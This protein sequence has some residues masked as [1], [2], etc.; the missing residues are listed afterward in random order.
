MGKSALQVA[1]DHSDQWDAPGSAV[2]LKT[3][4]DLTNFA[5]RVA[6]TQMV[7]ASFQGKP[8]EIVACVMRGMELQIPPFLAMSNIAVINGRPTMWGDLMLGLV[9]RSGALED[10]QEFFVKGENGDLTAI[11]QVKRRGKSV[12][13]RKFSRKD[14]DRARLTTKKGPHQDYPK[15]MLQL[16]ARGFA[17]RD[18]FPD[19]LT[20]LHVREVAEED[21]ELL[22][23]RDITPPAETKTAT[24]ALASK[25]GAKTD[26]D[27]TEVID[28]ERE[29]FTKIDA[30]ANL[31]EIQQVGEDLAK[32]NVGSEGLRNHY[33]LKLEQI[34]KESLPA[35]VLHDMHAEGMSRAEL[36]EKWGRKIKVLQ[37]IDEQ[38][39]E[40][41]IGAIDHHFS[42][43]D[44]PQG[45]LLE[46]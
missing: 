15:R 46:D 4:E 44:D 30:A 45:E 42:D 24:A 29:W 34:M 18:A 9:H 35:L 13:E 37:R 21:A 38:A 27:T 3:F 17:L 7:P 40:A 32:A 19:V 1:Q 43:G 31:A 2:T 16:R 12:T 20:G 39:H 8:D 11:C 23:P 10:I 25:I 26:V 33:S 14:A 28:P 6:K 41:L 5:D 36:D 22:G